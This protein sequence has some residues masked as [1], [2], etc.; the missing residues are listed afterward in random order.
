MFKIIS[1]QGLRFVLIQYI[2][3]LGGNLYRPDHEHE[4]PNKKIIDYGQ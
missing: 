2:Y 3:C 1:S 4:N